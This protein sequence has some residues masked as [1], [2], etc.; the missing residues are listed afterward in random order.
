MNLLRWPSGSNNLP[1][2]GASELGPVQGVQGEGEAGGG[3]AGGSEKNKY[4]YKHKCK[5][6]TK[7]KYNKTITSTI[8]EKKN[9]TNAPSAK[10]DIFRPYCLKDPERK[11]VF[12]PYLIKVRRK[13]FE[14]KVFFGQKLEFSKAG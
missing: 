8:Q 2:A 9:T 14:H 3:G 4:K 12:P 10:K 5:N 6:T 11:T 1:G 13:C 7:Y